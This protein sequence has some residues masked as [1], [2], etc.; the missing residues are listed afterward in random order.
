M[1][2]NK[3]PAII[4]PPQFGVHMKRRFFIL[5]SL[6]HFSTQAIPIH[7]LC[8]IALDTVNSKLRYRT[9]LEAFGV[10]QHTDD[11]KTAYNRGY[12][13][14]EEFSLC[15]RHELILLG[16]NPTR[17]KLI[18]CSIRKTTAHAVC[19]IDDKYVMCCLLNSIRTMSQRYD[20]EPHV[21]VGSFAYYDGSTEQELVNSIN[22]KT[23][24]KW[25]KND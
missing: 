25:S 5:G 21:T 19:L 11:V 8:K 9:D 1:I 2:H 13:D 12:G 20:L 7:D 6:V 18:Y 24:K 22:N 10:E 4:E 3:K 17:I 15:Y 23:L 16:I 14:C